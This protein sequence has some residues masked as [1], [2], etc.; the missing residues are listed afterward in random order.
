MNTENRTQEE[1]PT[2]WGRFLFIADHGCGQRVTVEIGSDSNLSDTA[3]A[4]ETFLVAAGFDR[5][6]VA[7]I[8]K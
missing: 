7:E 4:I 8:F 3:D 2:P 1:R 6:Q 5:E